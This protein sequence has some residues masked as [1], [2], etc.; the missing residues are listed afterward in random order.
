MNFG[1]FIFFLFLKRKE[2]IFY[3]VNNDTQSIDLIFFL[4]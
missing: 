3:S 2:E 4:A 1:I